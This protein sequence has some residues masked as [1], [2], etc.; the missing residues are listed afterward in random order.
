ML[1]MAPKD[2]DN[3]LQKSGEVYKF[4][5]PHINCAEE[6]IG[7]SG[8]TLGDRV[9]EHLRA[10]YPSTNTATPQETQAVQTASP[11]CTGNHNYKKHQGG[12]VH[13]GKWPFTKQ[14]LGQIPT[15]SHMG[16]YP[17]RHSSSS[18]QVKPAFPLLSH[19]TGTSHTPPNPPTAMGYNHLL[20]KC[21]MWGCYPYTP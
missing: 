12:H 18:T 14:E 20:G 9:E 5:C 11:S 2:T 19:P 4:K 10:P 21:T 6:Y 16:P 13:P 1:L 15:P 3:K 8:R 7:E 17:A